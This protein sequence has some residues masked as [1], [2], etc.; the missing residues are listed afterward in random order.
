M[1]FRSNHYNFY[2]HTLDLGMYN[3]A[4]Y[5]FAHFRT[6]QFKLGL[7]GQTTSFWGAHL[8]FTILLFAPLFY[9]FGSYTLLIVQIASI[10]LGGIGVYKYSKQYLPPIT[11]YI[12]LIYFFCIWGIYS[13]L[14]FDYHSNVVAAMI[15]PWFV[16]YYENSIGS[17]KTWFSFF[18][19]LLSKENMALWLFFIM[20]GLLI[21]NKESALKHLAINIAYISI[22]MLYF[23]IGICFLM[24][25]FNESLG[26][27]QLDRYSHLGN[28]IS[29]IIS[30]IITNPIDT[31]NLLYENTT[32]Y[33]DYDNI[34]EELHLMVL[35]SGGIALLYRPVF[36]IML[37]PIYAQKFLSNNIVMWGINHQYSIEFASILPLAVIYSLKSLN[38]N[39]SI[40]IILATIL[41]AFT[42][43]YNY[44]KINGRHSKWY[45]PVNT[46]FWSSIHYNQDIDLQESY[47]ILGLIPKNAA[48]CAHETLV[49]HLAFR[50][51]ISLFPNVQNSDY[52]VIIKN[53]RGYYPMN[54]KDFENKLNEIKLKGDYKTFKES[55]DLILLERK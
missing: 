50:K 31:I 20:I 7:L 39:K 13:A 53:K 32:N 10:L 12:V 15:V 28:G 42:A 3:N 55:K 19:I 23:V 54:K 46:K 44:K 5:D 33:S 1:L 30:H 24:P 48:V 8:D 6:N 43:A 22:P 35:V 18:F 38:H 11:S 27:S 34:K 51:N 45:S 16:Y 36:L 26:T 4:L 2:S 25:L 29:E 47:E 52:I 14:S 21:K 37:I 9:L 17:W 41:L 40:Q 49:P